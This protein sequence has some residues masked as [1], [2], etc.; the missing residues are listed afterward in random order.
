M[1]V[2]KNERLSKRTSE[3]LTSAAKWDHR[4][5]NPELRSQVGPSD[6]HS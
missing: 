1:A 4:M 5:S 3:I 6:E 2:N